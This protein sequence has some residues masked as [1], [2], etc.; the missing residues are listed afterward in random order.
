MTRIG[1]GAVHPQLDWCDVREVI[2]AAKDLVADALSSHRIEVEIHESAPLIRTDQ[3]LLEQCLSNLL[4]NAASNCAIG[5]EITINVQVGGNRLVIA[6]RDK[7][8]GIVESELPHI[9]KTFYRG[10]DVRPGGTGLGLAIVD[11]FVRALGGSVTAANQHPQGAEFVITVPV[12]TLRPEFM[13][14]SA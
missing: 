7:G 10:A 2:E 5:S 3:P 4:L 1:A 6:V 8:K 14:K 13:E 11:G 12:E 9:F